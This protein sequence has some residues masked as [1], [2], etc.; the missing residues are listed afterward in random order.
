[1]CHK[2]GTLPQIRQWH[3]G[4]IIPRKLFRLAIPLQISKFR[5]LGNPNAL[6]HA[7][8]TSFKR[9]AFAMSGM[10]SL[11][12]ASNSN[13]SSLES[14][15]VLPVLEID[16]W[17]PGKI[18]AISLALHECEPGTRQEERETG[19]QSALEPKH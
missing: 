12:G 18:Q 8:C 15:P 4:S 9:E 3:D 16:S 2:T 1:V 5:N 11:N 10:R 7:R 14:V 17:M 6:W 19:V 13:L